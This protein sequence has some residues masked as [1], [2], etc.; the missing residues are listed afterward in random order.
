[1]HY[2]ILPSKDEALPI[3]ML[4]AMANGAYI[5]VS[6]VGV[7]S[8][9]I[10]K[11]TTKLLSEIN[12]NTPMLIKNEILDTSN[13]LGELEFK[14]EELKRKYSNEKIQ[15]EIFEVMKKVI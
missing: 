2:F 5:I 12:N 15:A 4:E 6:D 7:I 10:N 13:K 1:M 11:N 8:E 9:F 3:S 14:I